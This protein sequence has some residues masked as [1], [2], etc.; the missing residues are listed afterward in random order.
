MFVHGLKTDGRAGHSSSEEARCKSLLMFCAVATGVWETKNR[1]SVAMN[2]R[3]RPIIAR[4]FGGH[5]YGTSA[6]PRI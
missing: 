3:V 1:E 4:T 2:T 6:L 5:K